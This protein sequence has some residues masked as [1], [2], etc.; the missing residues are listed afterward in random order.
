MSADNRSLL[1]SAFENCVSVISDYTK[2][3]TYHLVRLDG[4]LGPIRVTG[5]ELTVK[6]TMVTLPKLTPYVETVLYMD[7]LFT[8]RFYDNG[9]CAAYYAFKY[10]TRKTEKWYTRGEL[11]NLSKQVKSD[12]DTIFEFGAGIPNRKECDD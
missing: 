1:M 7:A 4:E 3:P 10:D 9:P 5:L 2:D 12:I 6:A 11:P 8:L